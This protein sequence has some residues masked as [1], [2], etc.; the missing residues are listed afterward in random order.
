MI[1]MKKKIT[2]VGSINTDFVVTSERWA[3]PGET[4]IGTSFQTT[5]GGKGGN[6]AIA[7]A[8][9]G[10]E[11]TMIGRVGQDVFADEYLNNFREHRVKTDGVEKVDTSTGSA[12]ITVAQ[13]DNSIIVVPGAND[14]L[15]PEDMEEYQELLKNCD[16]VILQ[17]ETPADTIEYVV[18]YC[19]RHGVDT[20][21]NPAP[22]REIPQAVI[23]QVT[24]LTPNETE[25]ALM[26]PD[27]SYEEACAQYPKKL[28]ITLGSDGA[29]FNNGQEHINVPAFVVKPI[30]TTGA[31][32]TFNGALAVAITSGMDLEEGMAFSNL[33]SS[34]SV[35]KFGAQ[36]GMPTLTE[37][38]LHPDY[39]D[40]WNLS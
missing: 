36:G 10:G 2:V 30:D 35:Q 39:Q 17:Q 29:V 19:H 25:F 26:F 22:A 33:A 9:L 3:Q 21:L 24:Y 32:D 15:Q 23:D 40:H 8:K 28:I 5:F 34:L 27:Q 16:L 4:I 14:Y 38:R 13:Q 37:M 1:T 12:H 6:Q 7:A 11:V 31:G 18:D 20:L